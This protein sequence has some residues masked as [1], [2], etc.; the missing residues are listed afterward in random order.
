MIII[1]LEGNNLLSKIIIALV[2]KSLLPWRK[3]IINIALVMYIDDNE[4]IALWSITKNH[5]NTFSQFM[6]NT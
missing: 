1:A 6:H 3:I 4:I 2:V 5:K